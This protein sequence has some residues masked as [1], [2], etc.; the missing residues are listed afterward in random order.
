MKKNENGNKLESTNY[1]HTHDVYRLII[2]GGHSVS[3]W[4]SKNKQK[5]INNNKKKTL[6]EPLIPPT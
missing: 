6:I 4:G 1:I 3:K 5:Q 2:S